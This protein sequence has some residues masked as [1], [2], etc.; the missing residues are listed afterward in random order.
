MADTL[1]ADI[2]EWQPPIDDSYP[3][4]WLSIRSNDGTYRDR[5]FAHNWNTARSWLD[6]G[7]LRGLIV[8]CVY[9]RNW[10]DVLDT[11]RQMQGE[12]RPD[13][14]S[15][16]DVES[17]GGQIAGDNSDPINRLVWGISDWRGPHIHGRPRRV[18]GYLNP[19]DAH[20]WPTRPPIGFVVP[21]YGSRPRFTA[22]TRDLAAQMI[23]HQC[24]DGQGYGNGLPEGYGTV[25]CDMNAANG[26][27]PDQLRA[28]TGIDQAAR[29]PAR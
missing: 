12:N 9:R 28:A 29:S 4:K 7:R 2:S 10:R 8:Y 20:I 19:H 6:S 27:D 21:S 11:H 15:M 13:V 24:T 1:F 5:N 3:Y 23:A 17:W 25:R 16:V 18:I 22:G 26:Y 14:V